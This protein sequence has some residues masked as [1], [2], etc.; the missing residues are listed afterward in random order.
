V[1]SG[2][3]LNNVQSGLHCLQGNLPSSPEL[4]A[5][6]KSSDGRL[7][8]HHTEVGTL[9]KGDKGAERHREGAVRNQGGGSQGAGHHT[10]L[11]VLFVS[12]V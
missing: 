10:G 11:C 12:C 3:S 5:S 1:Q 8:H 9:R 2:L 6:T 4:D 7:T